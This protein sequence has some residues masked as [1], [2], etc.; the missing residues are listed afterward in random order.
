MLKVLQRKN[1]MP[2]VVGMAFF[3]VLGINGSVSESAGP[4][5][6]AGVGGRHA[7]EVGEYLHEVAGVA[8]RENLVAHVL[9]H[10]RL[11]RTALGVHR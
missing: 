9:T 7:G 4:E 10:L 11:Q 3:G 8:A 1:A 2:A 6:S 5:Q